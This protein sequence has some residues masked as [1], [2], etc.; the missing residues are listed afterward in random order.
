ML[1]TP[2]ENEVSAGIISALNEMEFEQVVGFYRTMR[3]TGIINFNEHGED[4]KD[5]LAFVEAFVIF[6]FGITVEK[7]KEHVN[8]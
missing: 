3:S 4:I 7:F 6:R 2:R 1:D 8:A 5:M